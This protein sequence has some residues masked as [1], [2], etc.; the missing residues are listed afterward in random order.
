MHYFV[1]IVDDKIHRKAGKMENQN[2]RQ[3]NILLLGETGIGKSTWING[4]ANYLTYRTFKE[5]RKGKI[6]CLIPTSFTL[7]NDKHEE[8]EIKLG[9]D[10]NESTERGQSATQ[11]PKTYKFCVNGIEMRIIDTPG[12]GDTRGIEKDKENFQNILNHIAGIDELHGICILLQPNIARLGIVFQYCVTELLVNLHADACKN[13]VFCFTNSRETFYRPG[14][15]IAPLKK[16]LMDS[17]TGITLS[18]E[19][20]YCMDNEAIRFLAAITQGKKVTFST[21]EKKN[22]EDSW[23]TSVDVSVKMLEHFKNIEPHVV[24]NTLSINDCRRAISTILKPLSDISVNLQ[25]N[26]LEMEKHAVELQS[27]ELDIEALTKKLY[28]P[29]IEIKTIRLDK[30]H[31][32]CNKCSQRDQYGHTEYKCEI[33]GIGLFAS[34]AKTLT[35]GWAYC[36]YCSC[37][38]TEHDVI[39]YKTNTVHTQV[40]DNET[41]KN[42]KTK[43]D[44]MKV[45]EE[46]LRNLK[47]LCSE[48]Q[49]EQKLIN[50]AAANFAVFLKM[51]AITPFNDALEG[52][53]RLNIDGE[54]RKEGGGDQKE[55]ERLTKMQDD[56]IKVRK[57]IEDKS[58]SSNQPVTP[59]DIKRL[60]QK[61]YQM[62]HIENSF[63]EILDASE[64]AVSTGMECE[65]VDSGIDIKNAKTKSGGFGG[66]FT[67]SKPKA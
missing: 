24:K 49:E 31:S 9:E 21:K 17:K 32:V 8:I 22:F 36:T 59:T 56:Y 46:H 1:I 50:D 11:L 3:L 44:A 41:V 38:L 54:Q 67:S 64:H 29:K 25:E 40:I 19:I 35:L 27:E 34:Y 26:I 13:I 47:V 20:I 60:I 62:K 61:L 23:N 14:D 15:T 57:L 43:E 66:L 45:K 12:I 42:I 52:Y 33:E 51:C 4:F 6:K 58:K 5:A 48:L 10:A 65:E 28:I 55:V 53:L 63:K 7:T 39:N 2:K 16:L 30:P 37:Y 18:K